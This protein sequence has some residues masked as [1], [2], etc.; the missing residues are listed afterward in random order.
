MNLNGLSSTANIDIGTLVFHSLNGRTRD[1]QA[2]DG[3]YS[4]H[5]NITY[6]SPIIWRFRAAKI[7][8]DEKYVFKN[9]LWYVT[10][11]HKEI[12]HLA[13]TA[14]SAV[15]YEEMHFLKCFEY[16]YRYFIKTG[17]QVGYMS[18]ILICSGI[19]QHIHA[20]IRNKL[21]TMVII[22]SGFFT[23][24]ESTLCYMGFWFSIVYVNLG[25]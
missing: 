11:V 5:V 1:A 3:F 9:V 18:F 7:T 14:V 10:G 13:R 8:L 24:S 25:H 6:V 20:I 16:K 17:K 12:R 23:H 4:K 2:N 22:T 21:T 19:C 15:G